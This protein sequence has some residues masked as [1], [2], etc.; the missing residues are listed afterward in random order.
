M[1]D[2]RRPPPLPHSRDA[3]DIGL[4][5]TGNGVHLEGGD[6]HAGSCSLW[7]SGSKRPAPDGPAERCRLSSSSENALTVVFR[8]PGRR[9]SPRLP[10]VLSIL[11]FTA[12]SGA[13]AISLR[14]EML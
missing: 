12:L 4:A 8:I 2:G 10:D 3:L 7:P 9:I 1:R 5:V 6:P 14:L 11:V 13:E